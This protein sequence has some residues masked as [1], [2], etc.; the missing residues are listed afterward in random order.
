MTTQTAKNSNDESLQ[1]DQDRDRKQAEQDMLYK[2][3]ITIG[4]EGRYADKLND[5]AVGYAAAKGQDVSAARSEIEQKFETT[6]GR[7]PHEYLELH[8]EQR[9]SNGRSR[10]RSSGR[11]MN[12]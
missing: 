3:K 4:E 1:R 5:I 7:T 10:D 6:F 11:G 12:R 8:F 9:R 2:L